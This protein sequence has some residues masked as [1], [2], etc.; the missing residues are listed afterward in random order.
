MRILKS[1]YLTDGKLFNDGRPVDL[2]QI[3]N[4]KDFD[5]LLD[6]ILTTGYYDTSYFR[7]H[8]D[9]KEGEVKFDSLFLS[10]ILQFLK[11]KSLL[12]LG[13]GRGDVLFLLGLDHKIRVRGIEFS[14]DIVKEVWPILRDKVDYGD[15]LEVCDEYS[16]Q[17]ITFDTFCA[18]DLWEHIH[19]QKL[20]DYIDS[21]TAIAEKDTIFFFSIPAFGNDGIFGE[22]FPLEFEE[23]REKFN[24]RLP[25][26]YLIVESK[27]PPI[28]VKGHL[29]CAHSEWWQRQFGKH[30]LVRTPELEKLVHRFFDEHLFYARQSFYLFHPDTIEAQSRIKGLLKKPMTLYEKW[31]LI[32][33]Q[34]KQIR[35]FEK[36]Q[37]RSFIDLEELKQTINHAEFH[38]LRDM[39][40][41]IEKWTH[42][43]QNENQRST[44]LTSVLR[45]GDRRVKH[46]CRDWLSLY[47]KQHYL[48]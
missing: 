24:N 7:S 4:E 38:M 20:H 25:F 12:E 39:E 47:K 14:P 31:K 27:E 22:L 48:F 46:L 17:G 26:D 8:I 43:E 5:T 29:I 11:P 36:N 2:I 9:Y 21:I 19:P 41:R 37:G 18:F 23:N 42:P 45:F 35:L 16:K 32:V 10:S 40:K 34:Q 6:N 33:Y 13:C 1:N 44:L 3:E 30:G 15:I 28:P